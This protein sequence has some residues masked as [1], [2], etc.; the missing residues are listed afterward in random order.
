MIKLE[1]SDVLNFIDKITKEEKKPQSKK[2]FEYLN[3]D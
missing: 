1:P 2:G 3:Y